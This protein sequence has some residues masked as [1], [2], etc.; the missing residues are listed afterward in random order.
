[1]E[2]KGSHFNRNLLI[3]L[4][5]MCVLTVLSMSIAEWM[6]SSGTVPV[7]MVVLNGLILLIPL[8]LLFGAI[9]ILAVG[10]REYR[11]QGKI[12][13]RLSRLI[14]WAPR[15]ASILIILFLTLF[16]FDVFSGNATFWQMVGGF[17]VHNLPGI[18]LLILLIFAW[19]RPIVGFVSFFIFALAFTAF[20]V[21]SLLSPNLLFFVLP[22]L[23]IAFLFYA[24]WR[25]VRAS[26]TIENVSPDDHVETP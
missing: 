20:F 22:I 26:K 14:Q 21:R 18:V 10:W 12:R 15:I 9:Y 3:I 24:D 17:L 23:L 5:I 19:K 1:M 6:S 25:W 4:S 16:S 13:I 11:S 2:I 8:V 7:V